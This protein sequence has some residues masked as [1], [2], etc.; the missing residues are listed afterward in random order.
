VQVHPVQAPWMQYV[1]PAVIILLVMGLRLWRMRGARRLRLETLWILPALYAVLVIGMFA[2]HPPTPVGFAAAALALLVGGG[3]GWYRGTM[4]RI[5][6][7]PETHS[8]SQQASPLAV[9]LLFGLIVV[10]RVAMVEMGGSG[11][12]NAQLMI[13]VLMAF[14][15]GLIA[16]TRIEMLL[17]GRRLLREAR[18]GSLSRT[19][20]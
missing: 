13:D 8:L 11:G 14:A 12:F 20:S 7:D 5:S 18:A 3:I 10:R 2:A 1:V 16:A 4:M 15:L 9:L 17:R 6:V 19:F